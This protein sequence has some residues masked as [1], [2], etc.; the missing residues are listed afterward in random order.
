MAEQYVRF[1]SQHPT[2]LLR[3]NPSDELRLK[4]LLREMTVSADAKE[5]F[6]RACKESGFDKIESIFVRRG[7]YQR[8]RA[9]EEVD[10]R[11]LLAKL[12]EMERRI[13]EVQRKISKDVTTVLTTIRR[14]DRFF[15]EDFTQ[16]E[17]KILEW[18]RNDRITGRECIRHEEVKLMADALKTKHRNQIYNHLRRLQAKGVVIDRGRGR[19][20]EYVTT[21]YGRLLCQVIDV[22]LA[23][24]LPENRP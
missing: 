7:Y 20:I 21:H 24:A 1:L 11:S 14:L 23:Q 15:P 16:R 6:A 10:I 22:L 5:E 17:L 8:T 19:K 13:A 4:Q 3:I 9:S 2:S 18:I 12:D